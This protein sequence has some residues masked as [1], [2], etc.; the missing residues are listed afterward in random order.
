MPSHFFVFPIHMLNVY[1]LRNEREHTKWKEHKCIQNWIE[2]NSPICKYGNMELLVF[3]FVFF[4]LQA[5]WV[6]VMVGFTISVGVLN[7]GMF[8]ECCQLN[9]QIGFRNEICFRFCLS[10]PFFC[11]IVLFKCLVSMFNYFKC[12][13][14][15]INDNR[16]KCSPLFHFTSIHCTNGE[17]KD[18]LSPRE[19]QVYWRF[20]QKRSENYPFQI[21]LFGLF[22]SE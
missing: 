12:I 7:W 9:F 2:L 20:D 14:N 15:Y 21:M 13:Y 11:W 22:I 19:D 5:R 4:S 8:V 16:I 18:Y 17:K 10:I 3:G 1:G 6:Y